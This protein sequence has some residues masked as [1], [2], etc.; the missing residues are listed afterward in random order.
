MPCGPV[1]QG[2]FFAREKTETFKRKKVGKRT[3]VNRARALFF[4][5]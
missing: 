4:V 1:P 2:I 3:G 5:I